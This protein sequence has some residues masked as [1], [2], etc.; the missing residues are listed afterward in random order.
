MSRSFVS[1][2]K[3]RPITKVPKS[4]MA[5]FKKAYPSSK[6]TKVDQVGTG[7]TAVYHFTMADSRLPEA[8]ITA[9][10]KIIKK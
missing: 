9:A 2:T 5:T 7:K 1:G 8:R 4:V 6:V 10:G 3:M